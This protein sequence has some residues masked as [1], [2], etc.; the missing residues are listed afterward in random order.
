MKKKFPDSVYNPIT[1]A[2]AAIAVLSF[3]LV[4]F[5]IVLDFFAKEQNPYMGIITFIML[6]SVLV[7]GLLL[8]AYGIFREHRRVKSGKGASKLPFLDLNDPK[9]RTSALIFAGGSLLL[10]VFTAFGSFKAY[11][12]TESDKFCGLIC[13]KVMEPEFTAY[14]ASPHSK[15]GCVTCHI[16]SGAGWFIKSKLSG[17]YQVYSVLFNKFPTPIPTPLHNLRPAR[18][19]CEQCHW[20]N[21]FYS[22]KLI[23]TSYY[24]NDEENSKWTIKI[25]LKVGAG[26]P[27]T[28]VTSGIHWHV[29]DVNEVRYIST[30]EK[31]MEIPVVI[32]KGKDGKDII[33]KT[34]R[35]LPSKNALSK[36]ETRTMDCIDCHNHPAHIYNPSA[37]SIN[38]YMSVG[39]IKKELPY[40]K[41]ISMQALDKKYK[42]RQEGIASIKNIVEDFYRTNYPSIYNDQRK[43]ITETINQLTQI[44][45][46][47]YFPEMGVS[48]KKYPM[49]IGHMFA[50]GCFRCHDGLHKSDQ[51]K[52]ISKDCNLCHIITSQQYE[53]ETATFSPT[54]LEFKHP[55]EIGKALNQMNCS[56]CH[57][58]E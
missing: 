29:K 52:V 21:K 48:W 43:S 20:T 12:Y 46:R 31:R 17:S 9:H 35:N 53:N 27:E 8:I 5:L 16:G 47:N 50:P 39:K 30:D 41:S 49:Q 42:T 55:I 19:T 45:N 34:T 1:F 26:N 54:G 6:P 13:H 2:G 57:T 24:L 36:L 15:V 37:M 14:Q 44:F 32:E 10:L 58:K 7:F 25:A 33:Y 22:E 3:A 11:E 51:G 56:D 23:T 28:G 38:N 18:E 4:L 40:V